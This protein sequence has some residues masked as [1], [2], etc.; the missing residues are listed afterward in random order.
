VGNG[1]YLL[2][3]GLSTLSLCFPFRQ[4]DPRGLALARSAVVAALVL[5]RNRLGS[6]GPGSAGPGAVGYRFPV[7]A[8]LLRK[9]EGERAEAAVPQVPDAGTND[10]MPEAP[11]QIPQETRLRAEL[12]DIQRLS[13]AGSLEDSGQRTAGPV[14]DVGTA[15]A[16]AMAVHDV[17]SW[18]VEQMRAFLQ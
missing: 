3:R 9:T 14:A 12:E 7:P 18:D 8:R 2:D 13:A 15:A 16:A 6:A 4:L 5:L 17:R 1:P 10:V 11:V